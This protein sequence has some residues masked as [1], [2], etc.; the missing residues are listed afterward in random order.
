M[1]RK[2]ESGTDTRQEIDDGDTAATDA[3]NFGGIDECGIYDD[4]AE[5]CDALAWSYAK[6]ALD[7]EEK[8]HQARSKERF[9][10]EKA[11]RLRARSAQERHARGQANDG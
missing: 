10:D 9:Y 7:Y 8:A 5:A 4:E 6:K 11:R 3:A 2:G 1:E